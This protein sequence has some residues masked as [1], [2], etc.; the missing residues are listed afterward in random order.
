[1]NQSI[2]RGSRGVR[3]ATRRAFGIATALAGSVAL[4]LAQAQAQS[5]VPGAA[6]P[7]GM[8]HAVA[9]LEA[10]GVQIYVCRRDAA[11]QPDMDLS[12]AT[13]RSLRRLRPARRQARRRAVVGSAGRQPDHWQAAAARANPPARRFQCCSSLP[14]MR[15]V[16]AS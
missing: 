15:A 1:M 14:P 13:S 6:W 16:R 9:S 11:N 8:T 5:P 7:A 4:S 3:L 2:R 10:S 12:G